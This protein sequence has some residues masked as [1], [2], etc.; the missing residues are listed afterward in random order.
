MKCLALR[1]LLG[2]PGWGSVS[3]SSGAVYSTIDV[4]IPPVIEF[5]YSSLP[6]QRLIR[7]EKVNDELVELLVAKSI[8]VA[9]PLGGV[10]KRKMQLSERVSLEN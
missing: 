9:H 1:Q 10:G 7:F 4:L 3:A 6:L 2:I 5:R 8:I